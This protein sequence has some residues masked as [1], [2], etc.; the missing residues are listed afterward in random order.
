MVQDYWTPAMFSRW[1]PEKV[2]APASVNNMRS[3]MIS[4][5]KLAKTKKYSTIFPV[6]DTS[7][8]PISENRKKLTP[9]VKLALPRHESLMKTIDKSETL[10]LAQTIG[11]PIPKTFYTKNTSDVEDAATKIKYPAV[12]KP[13]RSWEFREKKTYF[14]HP[15]YANSASELVSTYTE[16]EKA[17]PEAMIQ[18]YIP[19]HNMQI[20]LIFDHGKPMAACAIRE[21]RTFPVTG[22][23]S[24]LRETVN[25]DPT[26]LEYASNLLKSLNWH[27][28]AEVE[29]RV[30]SRDLTPKLMEINPRFW[31]SMNV[32]IESGVDFPYL[33]YLLAKEKKINPI[34]KY[35]TGIK[36]RLLTQD[37]K[38]L[39]ITLK[40]ESKLAQTQPVNKI[41]TI[42]NFLKIYETNLHYDG[43]K[44]NDPLPFFMENTFSIYLKSRD[45]LKQKVRP[46][47]FTEKE[48][49]FFKN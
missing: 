23:Q 17:F 30:D 27:G 47:K 39:Q 38:N 11:I 32:A 22:G 44:V 21:H 28:I 49:L 29:F 19:G 25:L 9:Y 48:K 6:Y 26:I 34:F 18:E 40:N 24:V 12:I 35:R 37:I 33:L 1:R 10:K 43:L 45:W 36:F 5:I 42:L 8:I 7:L 4:L 13:K 16:I 46:N 31:G 15:F 14:S 20:G 41:K 3:F 2:Y